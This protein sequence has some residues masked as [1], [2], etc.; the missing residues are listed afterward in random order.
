MI[1]RALG[2]RLPA[3]AVA[4]I[5]AEWQGIAT[6][7]LCVVAIKARKGEP[8]RARRRAVAVE[9]RAAVPPIVQVTA[10]A[11]RARGRYPY[12]FY[13]ADIIKG[14]CTPCTPLTGG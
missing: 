3:R 4:T 9:I 13:I 14:V 12:V 8:G 5:F 6:A 2:L 10:D 7:F 11:Q 1:S